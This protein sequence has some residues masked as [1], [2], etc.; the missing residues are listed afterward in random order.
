LA[1]LIDARRADGEPAACK[2]GDGMQR[3]VLAGL[4][5]SA[6]MGAA[7][8]ADVKASAPDAFLIEMTG[9]AP[10]ARE[11]AWSRLVKI[12]A[13]WS[14]AH[15]YSGTATSL[16]VDPVA[17]GCWCELW[18]GGEVE[19]G[20]VVLA[21]RDQM[22]RFETALG[23]LQELAVTGVLTFTLSDGATPDATS[24]ALQ[25]R[26]TGGSLSNLAA[27]APVVD[28]VISEQFKRLIAPG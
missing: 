28:G 1:S 16:S 27:I 25:Y 19:H 3:I 2:E 22:L 8:W 13:W 5:A 9:E 7:A 21:L 4:V 11:A 18:E 23:P 6:A 10:L 24:I 15:T 12:S 14:D 17:G 26:V 20:R